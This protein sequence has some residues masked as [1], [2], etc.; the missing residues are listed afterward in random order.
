MQTP[1]FLTTEEL[2]GSKDT[3]WAKQRAIKISKFIDD[4]ETPVADI[5]ERNPL[6]QFLEK[7]LKIDAVS[8]E[9]LD[10]DYEPLKGKYGTIFCF[11]VIEHLFNPLY[12]LENLRKALLND[13]YIYLS[14]PHRPHFLWTEHHF[15][16]MD[17][18]RIRWLFQRAG[19]DVVDHRRYALRDKWTTHLTGIR[20]FLR[21]FYK[22]M[23]LYKL[24]PI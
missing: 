8:I 11:A 17:R 9:G 1:T 12:A 4:I 3:Y 18:Q 2:W 7:E 14:T 13:G 21:Y 20:P 15:H 16:E 6:I 5:G 23:G 10:L 19:L 22:S 24:K